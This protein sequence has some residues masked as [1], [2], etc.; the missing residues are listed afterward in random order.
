[1]SI[2][3]VYKKS[4]SYSAAQEIF[5]SMKSETSRV[6]KIS[7]VKSFTTSLDNYHTLILF[8]NPL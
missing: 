3:D 1:M 4:D 7:P 6:E 2:L 5:C 8:S